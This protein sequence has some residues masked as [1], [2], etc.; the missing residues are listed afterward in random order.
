MRKVRKVGIEENF[1]A[2]P[3][4]KWWDLEVFPLKV[5]K[6]KGCPILYCANKTASPDIGINRKTEKEKKVLFVFEVNG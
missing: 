1:L 3:H 4:T 2:K 5:D 6:T